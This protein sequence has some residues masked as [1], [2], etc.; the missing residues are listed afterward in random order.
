M[1]SHLLYLFSYLS[2]SK[3]QDQKHTKILVNLRKNGL[4]VIL[5]AFHADKQIL[6]SSLICNPIKHVRIRQ[7]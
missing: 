6:V 5:Q 7:W 4:S 3:M 1:N 2:A